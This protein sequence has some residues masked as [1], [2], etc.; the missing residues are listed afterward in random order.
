MLLAVV[1]IALA[2]ALYGNR[3]RWDRADFD[4]YY[5]WWSEIRRGIDPWSPPHGAVLASTLAH[6]TEGFCDNT[7]FLVVALSPFAVIPWHT[8]YWLWMAVQIALLG[9]TVIVISDAMPVWREYDT[10]PRD[11]VSNRYAIALAGL[12][13]FIP[14]L[15][16]TIHGAQPV[17][18]MLFLATMAWY[19]DRREH[20]AASGAMLAAVTLLKAYPGAIGGYFLFKRRWR[21]LGWSVAFAI[22]GIVLTGPGRWIQFLHS[23]VAPRHNY[24]R[25]RLVGV[26]STVYQSAGNLIHR[27][28]LW[29]VVIP[30]SVAI[31]LI[32]VAIAAWVTLGSTDDTDIAGLAFGAWMVVALL[33]SPMTWDHELPLAIPVYWFAIAAVA[34]GRAKSGFG[35]AMLATGVVVSW[36]GEFFTALRPYHIYFIGTVAMFV[37]ACAMLSAWNSRSGQL[38]TKRMSTRSV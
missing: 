3:S 7:P 36:L 23:A 24:E 25:D 14:H 34:N 13:L 33:I 12:V 38:S 8:A 21:S 35:L 31:D 2:A 29:P 16:A 27:A 19:L 20:A 1:V 4:L 37:G 18:I 10:R 11:F 30:V 15:I 9:A 22:S 5:S 26:M 28:D 6:P 17:Y 32:I